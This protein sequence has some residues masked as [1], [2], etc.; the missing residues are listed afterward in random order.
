M[1]RPI[2]EHATGLT[3]LVLFALFA[4]FSPLSAKP[5]GNGGG[6]GG[7]PGGG[8]DEDPPTNPAPVEYQLTWLPGTYGYTEIHDINSAGI[9]VGR[10]HDETGT[11]RLFWTTSD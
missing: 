3:A 2:F 10:Y 1:K 8:G 11:P 7:N 9:A 5:G 6:G 4:A